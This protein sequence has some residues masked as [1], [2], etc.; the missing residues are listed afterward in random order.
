M[1][2]KT[3]HDRELLCAKNN[4]DFTQNPLMRFMNLFLAS[5]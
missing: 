1:S 5:V 2:S 3:F 4:S